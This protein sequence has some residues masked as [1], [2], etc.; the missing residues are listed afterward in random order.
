M[1]HKHCLENNLPNLVLLWEK[2]EYVK[3]QNFKRLTKA[4]FIIYA[5]FECILIPLTGN[6]DF[7]PNHQNHIVY[8]YDYKIMWVDKQYSKPYQTYIV[9]KSL[10]Q[11]L[12]T[13]CFDWKRSLRF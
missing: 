6:I 4:P 3:F 11:I 10:K 1:S 7:G 12:W 8:S 5:S 2:H 9:L 13:S